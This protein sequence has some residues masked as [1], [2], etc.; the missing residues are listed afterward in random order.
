MY[1]KLSRHWDVYIWSAL[2]FYP[3]YVCFLSTLVISRHFTYQSC[4]FTHKGASHT[5]THFKCISG[6]HTHFY[7]FLLPPHVTHTYVDSRDTHTH[8]HTHTRTN[9]LFLSVYPSLY[10]SLCSIS[11]FFSVHLSLSFF[12]SQS[13]G[14][15]NPCCGHQSLLRILIERL[16]NYAVRKQNRS[17]VKFGFSP[18]L[19]DHIFIQQVLIYGQNQMFR[20][21]CQS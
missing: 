9:I 5:H 14:I 15:W 17:I 2:K 21:N 7:Y 13:F 3:F 18:K 19:I 8:T 6:I 1:P 20:N 16:C 4:L 11:P 10:I 12:L